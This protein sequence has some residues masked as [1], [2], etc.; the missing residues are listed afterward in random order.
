[1]SVGGTPYTV[2]QDKHF[3]ETTYLGVFQTCHL[4]LERHLGL[5][6]KSINAFSKIRM[7]DGTNVCLQLPLVVLSVIAVQ[8]RLW[9]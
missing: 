1:M 6:E 5:Q 4:L 9:R 7:M 8:R 2:N 3:E